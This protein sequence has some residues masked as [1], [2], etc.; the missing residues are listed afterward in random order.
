MASV[1]VWVCTNNPGT[2]TPALT[3][4][5]VPT[6]GDAGSW[7]QVQLQEPFDPSSLDSGDLAAALSAGFTVMATGLVIAWA[8]RQVVRAIR[9]AL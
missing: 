7:Q 2:Y 5:K 3:S 1:T 8:A 6:C 9:Q 4:Y